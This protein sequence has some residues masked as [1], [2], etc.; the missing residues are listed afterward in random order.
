MKIIAILAITLAILSSCSERKNTPDTNKFNY[1]NWPKPMWLMDSAY[2]RDGGTITVQ[3]Q[4]DNDKFLYLWLDR[5]HKSKTYGTLFMSNA[6][7]KERNDGI[8]VLKNSKE[9]SKIISDLNYLSSLVSEDLM[10]QADNLN[11]AWESHTM[12]SGHVLLNYGLG[13]YKSFLS[14]NQFPGVKSSIK[15]RKPSP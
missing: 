11:K 2:Y 8:K 3:I 1:T 6:E 9:H 5:Q 7:M 14:I 12:R 4:Y 13:H 10:D 15:Q